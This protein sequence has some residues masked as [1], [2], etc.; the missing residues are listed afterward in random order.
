MDFCAEEVD[1]RAGRQL[2]GQFLIHLIWWIAALGLRSANSKQSV[3]VT[4][5]VNC[6]GGNSTLDAF[7]GGQCAA[8]SVCSDLSEYATETDSSFAFFTEKSE[9]KKGIKSAYKPYIQINA[10]AW[11]MYFKKENGGHL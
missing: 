4:N 5:G 9:I 11:K 8:D 1:E 3:R 6:L 2:S 10:I 7:Y